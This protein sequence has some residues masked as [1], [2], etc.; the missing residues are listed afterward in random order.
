MTSEIDMSKTVSH[1][2]DAKLSEVGVSERFCT[3]RSGRWTADE[4]KRSG[5]EETGRVPRVS[6]ASH[7]TTGLKC[8]PLQGSLAGRDNDN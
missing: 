2:E 7:P 8:L 1:G 5:R 4:S 3:R 6:E